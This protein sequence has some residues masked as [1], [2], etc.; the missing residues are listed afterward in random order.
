MYGQIPYSLTVGAVEGALRGLME[1]FRSN[2]YLAPIDIRVRPEILESGIRTATVALKHTN[3]EHIANLLDESKRTGRTLTVEEYGQIA[4]LS[5]IPSNKRKEISRLATSLNDIR[6]DPNANENQRFTA[7]KMERQIHQT[8]EDHIVSSIMSAA[9]HHTPY[10]VRRQLERAKGRANL[11]I[12]NLTPGQ[13]AH[14]KEL[15]LNIKGKK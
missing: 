13:K 10:A 9:E 1:R 5:K 4:A 12:Y 15:L 7:N 8:I 11:P 6:N 2:P 14:A 3:A